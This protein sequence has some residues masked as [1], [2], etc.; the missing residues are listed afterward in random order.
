MLNNEKIF[1]KK[2]SE[3]NTSESSIRKVNKIIKKIDSEYKK[4]DKLYRKEYI[5]NIN[6]IN[7]GIPMNLDAGYGPTRFYINY[8]NKRLKK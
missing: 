5:N 2:L 7:K 1:Q 6:N 3:I 4:N 8:D